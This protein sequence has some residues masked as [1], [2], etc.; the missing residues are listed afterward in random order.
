MEP[1]YID[2]RAAGLP[3]RAV[4][5]RS[6]A[7]HQPIKIVATD[8]FEL[9]AAA[10]KPCEKVID[11]AVVICTRQIERPAILQQAVLL[12]ERA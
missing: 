12:K 7:W 1:C 8:A 4:P 5:L 3:D 11:L 9:R 2:I 10:R 6:Q